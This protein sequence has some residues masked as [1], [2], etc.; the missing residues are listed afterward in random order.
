MERTGERG[1]GT[2]DHGPH[3]AKTM[4][5]Q[6]QH[7]AAPTTWPSLADGRTNTCG[8]KPEASMGAAESAGGSWALPVEPR[9]RSF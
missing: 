5:N 8:P 2:R 9:K 1:V 3:G 4:A 6:R 7:E